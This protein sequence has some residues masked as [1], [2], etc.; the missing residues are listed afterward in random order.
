MTYEKKI[1]RKIYLT[2][3]P[4]DTAGLVFSQWLSN[5]NAIRWHWAWGKDWK[6]ILQSLINKHWEEEGKKIYSNY[7]MALLDVATGFWREDTWSIVLYIPEGF[8]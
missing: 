2:A 6:F 7:N 8:K 3:Y 5:D 4:H 1:N